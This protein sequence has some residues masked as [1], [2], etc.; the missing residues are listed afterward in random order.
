MPVDFLLGLPRL[1]KSMRGVAD[2]VRR[3][4]A[5]GS[6]VVLDTNAWVAAA[7]RRNEASVRRILLRGYE[8]D[9]LFGL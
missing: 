9:H 8:L 3:R 1:S 6:C 5:A 7:A 2:V 4:A